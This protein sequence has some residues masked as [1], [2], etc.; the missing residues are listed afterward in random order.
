MSPLTFLVG[1]F[2]DRAQ[3][4]HFDTQAR[5]LTLVQL[6]EPAFKNYTWVTRSPTYE[7]IFYASH[8][9]LGEDEGTVSVVRLQ[10]DPGLLERYRLEVLQHVS[11]GGVDPC[12][13]TVSPSGHEL[14][15]ANVSGT[16]SRCRA[17]AAKL[18]RNRYLVLKQYCP[19]LRYWT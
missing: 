13:C 2:H 8:T 14:A 17:S 10:A 18:S 3:L 19:D 7:S 5:S 11:S 4:L 12:H 9:A 16:R 15:I 1:S 6:P